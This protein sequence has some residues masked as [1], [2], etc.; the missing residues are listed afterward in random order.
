MS[1]DTRTKLTVDKALQIP[2]DQPGAEG[3]TR[4]GRV[5]YDEDTH[6]FR[7]YFQAWCG[8]SCLVCALDS[9]DGTNWE[10]PDIGLVDFDGSKENNITNCP[11][12]VRSQSVP[13]EPDQT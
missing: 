13:F 4:V 10:R 2:L 9:A 1:S 7:M 3:G 6:V 11:P 5:S 8:Y 12:E